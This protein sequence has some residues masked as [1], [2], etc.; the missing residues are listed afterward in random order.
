MSARIR[1]TV[2]EPSVILRQGIIA[3]LRQ[4]G[5]PHLEVSEA[6]DI[7]KLKQVILLQRP[8]ILIV[9]P[10]HLGMFSVQQ[11]RKEAPGGE[12]KLVALQLSMADSASLKAYDEVV[13]LYDSPE[14]IREKLVRI[15]RAPETDKR[16]E[17]LS[18]REREVVVCVVQGMTNKQIADKLC[19]STHTVVTHRRNIAS[20]L[21]IHSTAGLAIYAIVNKLVELDKISAATGTF[22]AD[23]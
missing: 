11:I 5:T 18:D 23:D 21:D 20:K 1:I 16:H 3:V 13:S 15:V 14:Q 7:G 19:L 2:A 22:G 10:A 9:N 12:M 17:L 6:E 4:M 8:D